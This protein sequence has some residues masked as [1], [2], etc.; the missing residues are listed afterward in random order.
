MSNKNF[1]SEILKSK[2]KTGDLLLFSGQGFISNIIKLASRSPWSHIG[3]IFGSSEHGFYCWESDNN[4]SDNHAA[5]VRKVPLDDKINHYQGKVV[6][7]QLELI[8]NDYKNIEQTIF[9]FSEEVLSRPYESS[10]A[11]LIKSAYDGPFGE[12]IEDLSSIFCSEL[13]AEAYQR[14][15]LLP[16]PPQGLPSN[17]YTPADFA[18]LNFTLLCGQLSKHILLKDESTKTASFELVIE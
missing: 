17:E 3:M 7:R 2:V 15:K 13:I 18:S 6:L 10:L 14:V 16:S 4:D 11:E 1:I 5:G 8:N 12:N 9:E